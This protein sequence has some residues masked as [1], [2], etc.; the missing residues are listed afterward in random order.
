MKEN[1]INTVFEGALRADRLASEE[2]IS[3]WK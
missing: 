3:L 1:T 2:K